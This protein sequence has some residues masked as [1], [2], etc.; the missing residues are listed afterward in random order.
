MRRS[1]VCG[2]LVS[3]DRVLRSDGSEYDIRA[4]HDSPGRVCH[5]EIIL[6]PVANSNW[7]WLVFSVR[8]G[9]SRMILVLISPLEPMKRAFTSDRVDFELRFEPKFALI[10]VEAM[11]LAMW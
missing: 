1:L 6:E 7:Y 9:S 3:R 5:P 2:L 8:F 11:A 10:E 4:S